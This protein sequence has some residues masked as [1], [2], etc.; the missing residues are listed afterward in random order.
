MRK[1]FYAVILILALIICISGDYP[2]TI[3]TQIFT[4]TTSNL[5]KKNLHKSSKYV[6]NFPDNSLEDVIQD[7]TDNADIGK[8]T[9][10]IDTNTVVENISYGYYYEQLTD[11]Q[12]I[13]YISILQNIE[14]IQK[15]H[16]KFLG[17]DFDDVKYA[18]NAIYY[19]QYE[20]SVSNINYYVYDT[21]ISVKLTLD[22]EASLTIIQLNKL[23]NRAQKISKNVNGT[24]E[25]IIRAIYNWCT[26]H[27]EYDYTLSKKHIRDVYGALINKKA[28]CA[29]Y[30]KA[31][32]Y[33][34]EQKG[35]KCSFI[36][37]KKHAW[38]YVYLNKKWYAIDTTWG[39]TN[40]KEYLLVGK[41]FLE[42]SEHI[43]SS[44]YFSFPEL[45]DESL[46]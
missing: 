32:Q 43:P 1:K 46:Y 8:G 22:K 11:C 39:A 35:I 44:K 27:I 2:R 3:N 12:K 40:S 41:E 36:S 7:L 20:Y 23:E 24:D 33:L 34:C 45:S 37:N 14:E 25:E 17:A 10:V 9:T 30:A 29:G 38:N 21:S 18:I 5:S 42:D 19:D 31:F 15:K 28:V 6:K 4:S 16:I 26:K 13:I